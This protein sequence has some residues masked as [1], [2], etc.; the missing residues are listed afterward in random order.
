VEELK[1]MYTIK[2]AAEKTG[3]DARAIMYKIRRKHIQAQKVGWIWVI[4]E[5]EVNKLTENDN[6]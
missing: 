6:S 1:K 5:E 2:E 4:S 3:L